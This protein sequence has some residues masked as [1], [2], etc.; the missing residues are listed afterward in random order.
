MPSIPLLDFSSIAFSER[1][2]LRIVPLGA[3]LERASKITTCVLI[4]L[5]KETGS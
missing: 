1:I 5:L 2:S 4:R 3:N